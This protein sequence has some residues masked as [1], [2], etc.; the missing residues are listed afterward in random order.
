MAKTIREMAKEKNLT[1]QGIHYLLD[2]GE[3]NFTR[4]G[5]QLLTGRANELTRS[6]A[7]R[8]LK[9]SITSVVRWMGDG[10]LTG[11]GKFILRDEK[12]ERVKN[13]N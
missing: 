7:A 8:Q 5:G 10:R 1:R 2:K 3:V 11:S 13:G 6:E 12:F 4:E 9:V